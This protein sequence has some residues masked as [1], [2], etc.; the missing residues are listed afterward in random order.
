MKRRAFLGTTVGCGTGLLAGCLSSEDGSNPTELCALSVSNREGTPQ[1]VSLQ[2][3]DDGEE[4]YTQTRQV[5]A[6]SADVT[7][8]FTVPSAELPEESGDYRIR[9]QVNESEW[10]KLSLAELDSEQIAVQAIVQSQDGQPTIS[11]WY[12]PSDGTCAAE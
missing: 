7:G 4:Q 9:A 1:N 5:E 6:G 10:A 2:V 8:G 11:L 12:S 3:I